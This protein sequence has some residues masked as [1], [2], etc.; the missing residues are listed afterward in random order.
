MKSCEQHSLSIVPEPD[1]WHICMK[2][3]CHCYIVL[4]LQQI[5]DWDGSLDLVD[6]LSK[7]TSIIEHCDS[8]LLDEKNVIEADVYVEHKQSR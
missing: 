6:F 3:T 4:L 2:L 8:A 7:I 1:Y 5:T